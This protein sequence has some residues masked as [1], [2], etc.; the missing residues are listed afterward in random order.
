MAQA[1]HHHHQQKSLRPRDTLLL[2][3]AAAMRRN[4]IAVGSM[5]LTALFASLLTVTFSVS[6]HVCIIIQLLHRIVILSEILKVRAQTCR[7]AYVTTLIF[8]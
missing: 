2:R 6:L 8:S 4:V 3:L 5:G 7:L 1:H